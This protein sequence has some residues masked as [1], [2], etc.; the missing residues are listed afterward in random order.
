MLQRDENVSTQKH[1]N[2]HIIV[3]SKVIKS[4]SKWAQFTLYPLT[5]ECINKMWHIDKVAY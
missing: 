1:K 3:H 5:D 4:N 2:W